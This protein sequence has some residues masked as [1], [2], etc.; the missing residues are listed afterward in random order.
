VC[1]AQTNAKQSLRS[2]GRRGGQR[3]GNLRQPAGK[4][5]AAGGRLQALE[6]QGQ[7]WIRALFQAQGFDEL[8]ARIESRQEARL[9]Q[10]FRVLA[11]RIGIDHDATADTESGLAIGSDFDGTNGDIEASVAIRRQPAQATGVQPAR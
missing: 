6:M 2:R 3:R 1:Q 5:E 7:Q 8:E 10:A 11:R 9:Q 4:T